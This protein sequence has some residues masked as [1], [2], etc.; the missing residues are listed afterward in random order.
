VRVLYRVPK[1]NRAVI[2]AKL[3]IASASR[4]PGNKKFL[5]SRFRGK[6]GWTHF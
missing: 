5:D 2:P 3:A 4:N 6:D 1:S